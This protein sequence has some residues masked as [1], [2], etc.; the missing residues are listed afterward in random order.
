MIY[1]ALKI[2]SYSLK[3]KP[4]V[5]ETGFKPIAFEVGIEEETDEINEVNFADL[6]ESKLYA[7]IAFVLLNQRYVL[8]HRCRSL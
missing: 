5:A 2:Y 3:K 4:L 6:S 8:G 1:Q 7:L